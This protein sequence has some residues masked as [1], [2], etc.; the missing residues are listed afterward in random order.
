MANSNI[1]LVRSNSVNDINTSII[2]I[3]KELKTNGETDINVN[4]DVNY[5]VA[6]TVE[7]GN[8]KPV[9]SG[10]VY[11]YA[12]PVDTVQDG[13]LKAVTS[14]AVYNNCVIKKDY[15]MQEISGDD[16]IENIKSLVNQVLTDNPFSTISSF[17]GAGEYWRLGYSWGSYLLQIY[18]Q[19]N[20]TLPSGFEL[21]VNGFVITYDNTRTIRHYYKV[22]LTND[23]GVNNIWDIEDLTPAT[24]RITIPCTYKGNIAVSKNKNVVCINYLET[25]N[26]DFNFGN[27]NQWNLIATLPEGYRPSGIIYLQDL[28]SGNCFK[29]QI[30]SNGEIYG[31]K[32]PGST[33]GWEIAFNTTFL[34]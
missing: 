27:E 14:N 25:D 6:T 18:R 31:Y 15:L 19:P 33:A 23:D 29:I 12:T 26:S 17:I 20:G 28:G 3:K 30:Y 9:T 7:E 11:D 10:A 2:A 8:S 22:C 34:V 24:Q 21:N 1:P 5:E 32:I 16:P 13:N 4:V